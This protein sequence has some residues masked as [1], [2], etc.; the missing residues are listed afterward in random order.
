MGFFLR[1][2]FGCHGRA[3]RSF[4]FNGHQFPICARCTGELIGILVSILIIIMCNNLPLIWSIILII[5]LIIDGSIQLLTKYESN[6]YL[7]VITGFLFG[8]GLCNIVVIAHVFAVTYIKSEMT[9]MFGPPPYF[10]L[11]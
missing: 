7:R 4:F 3:D 1:I 6:N 2:L 9:R 10:N 8:I 11:F 5:P